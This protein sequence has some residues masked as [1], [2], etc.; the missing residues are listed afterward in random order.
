MWVE[1]QS[2]KHCPNRP[3]RYHRTYHSKRMQLP[4]RRQWEDPTLFNKNY[5]M[6]SLLLWMQ[7]ISWINFHTF[8]SWLGRGN[9]GGIKLKTKVLRNGITFLRTLIE[10][11]LSGIWLINAED[12]CTYEEL[13][14][15]TSGDSG[16]DT[17]L[18]DCSSVG[19]ED[20]SQPVEGIRS[21]IGYYSVQRDL[22][23]D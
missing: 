9:E 20:N 23:C 22:T 16:G 1:V 17:K 7:N 11:A 4:R 12:V 6:F 21:C 14:N 2:T 18:H 15:H 10:R 19:S 8:S 5:I 3:I 13:H